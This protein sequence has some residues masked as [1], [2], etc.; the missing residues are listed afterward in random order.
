MSKKLIRQKTYYFIFKRSII[1][2]SL[3]TRAHIKTKTCYNFKN[4]PLNE[5]T[6]S[7]FKIFVNVIYRK[8]I[9]LFI[10][11]KKC[12]TH[13]HKVYMRLLYN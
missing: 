3:E 9:I 10:F 5:T 4:R 11:D 1:Y 2:E 12:R 8:N 6:I 13:I 7:F